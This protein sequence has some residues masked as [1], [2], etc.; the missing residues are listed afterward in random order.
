VALAA[1]G[2]GGGV[3]VEAA[4]AAGVSVEAAGCSWDCSWALGTICP[5]G[6]QNSFFASVIILSLPMCST[7]TNRRASNSV[8]LILSYRLL[9]IFSI[10][11]FSNIENQ[12]N[13]VFQRRLVERDFFLNT[14]L[15]DFLYLREG[16][17]RREPP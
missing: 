4:S 14:R 9:Y 16:R 5:S 11:Y 10:F 6:L 3:S 13:H 8:L 7:V 17:R 1:A 2:G 15:A 12:I